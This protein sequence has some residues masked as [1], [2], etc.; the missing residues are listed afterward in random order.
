MT[1]TIVPRSHNLVLRKPGKLVPFGIPGSNPG[2]GVFLF[3]T[4]LN[5]KLFS[6]DENKMSIILSLQGSM[7]VGKTTAAKYVQD[8]LP[9]VTVS[10]EDISS[11]ISEIKKRNLDKNTF[12]GYVEIQRLFIKAEIKRWTELKKY[13]L[14]LIDMGPGEIEFHTLHYPKA[15][16]KDWDVESALSQELDE[17]RKCKIDETLFLEASTQKLTQHKE[18]DKTRSRTFFDF[19]TKYMLDAKKKWYVERN[20]RF[21]N[22]DTLSKEEVGQVVLDWV[23]S[24]I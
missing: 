4:F 2:R 10:Y 5:T 6:V 24:F 13:P 9:D 17:L 20:A 1:K 15:L 23:K 22:V 21:V 14:S 3:I 16:S 19:Y 8:N 12:E 7:A 11:V 18:N